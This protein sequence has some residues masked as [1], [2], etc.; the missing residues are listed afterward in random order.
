MRLKILQTIAIV[1][2]SFIGT[3]AL[4]DDTL[5]SGN[6]LH[7]FCEDEAN[8]ASQ[9]FCMGYL[10]GFVEGRHWGSFLV[11]NQI[12]EPENADQAQSISNA[13]VGYCVPEAASYSQLLDIVKKHLR[14]Y[15]ESR[16]QTART[17]IWQSFLKAF[18]C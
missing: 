10:V 16:H 3:F 17:L 2:L 8:V 15:P 11:V 5:V 6:D 1:A 14:E 12:A 9:G 7:E 18:P 13:F 4:A